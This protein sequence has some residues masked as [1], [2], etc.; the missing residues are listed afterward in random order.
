MKERKEEPAP[1]PS[2]TR[3]PADPAA[4]L[5]VLLSWDWTEDQI[6]GALWST[7]YKL[8]GCGSPDVAQGGAY[9]S[10]TT[11][12]RTSGS[13][14]EEFKNLLM[15]VERAQKSLKKRSAG[16]PAAVTAPEE[17][18]EPVASEQAQHAEDVIMALPRTLPMPTRP[19]RPIRPPRKWTNGARPRSA[20]VSG[21]RSPSGLQLS[22]KGKPLNSSRRQS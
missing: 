3:N 10:P 17:R 22:R 14:A 6:A 19:I 4:V 15:A 7:G 12:G 16:T 2:P 20:T 11:T 8:G 1:V 18:T 13:K 9:G 5:A 21:F